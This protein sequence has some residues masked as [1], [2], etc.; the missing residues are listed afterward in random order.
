LIGRTPANSSRNLHPRALC[1]S[2]LSSPTLSVQPLSFQPLTHYHSHDRSSTPLQSIRYALFLSR[3]GMP[4]MALPHDSDP[5]DCLF[6]SPY[7]LY[8]Q[9]LE[10]YFALFCTPQKINSFIFKRFR[11]LCKKKKRGLGEWVSQ[12]SASFWKFSMVKV[13]N[14]L[15]STTRQSRVTK[16]GLG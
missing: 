13:G 9:Y 1:V 4:A 3:R 5:L 8:F 11:T 10:N 16:L 7:L 15:R 6:F 14:S 2:P 12:R